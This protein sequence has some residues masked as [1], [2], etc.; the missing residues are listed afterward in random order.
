MACLDEAIA[1]MAVLASTW[2][3]AA[4]TTSKTKVHLSLAS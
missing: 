1:D 4:N 3:T 2:K